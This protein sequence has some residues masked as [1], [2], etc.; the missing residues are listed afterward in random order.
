MRRILLLLS[1]LLAVVATA[2]QVVI[3]QFEVVQLSQDMVT[4][5]N[6]EGLEASFPKDGSFFSFSY[7]SNEMELNIGLPLVQMSFEVGEKTTKNRSS[8]RPWLSTIMNK[9]AAITISSEELSL[10][11]GVRTGKS[12]RFE[13]TPVRLLDKTVLTKV[14]ISDPYSPTR[15]EN[16]LEINTDE[17][18]L[19]GF[20]TIK[21]DE[22]FQHVALYVKASVASTLPQE[23]VYSSGSLDEMAKVFFEEVESEPSE[24]CGVLI[25]DGDFQGR[26]NLVLWTDA[27]IVLNASVSI[28]SMNF[29]AGL[30][31]LVGSEGLRAGAR[32][33]YG[34]E[35]CLALG[36]SDVSQ[37]TNLLSL[38]ASLYPIKISLQ[39][40]SFKSPEWSFGAVLSFD[41]ITIKLGIFS[42]SAMAFSGDVRFNFTKNFFVLLGMAYDFSTNKPSFR[43]GFGVNF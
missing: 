25:Y 34:Q 22:G 24:V 32:I 9:R 27:G 21:K 4:K 6:L 36:F 29:V 35:V 28:P 7:L 1:L 11:T 31:K 12:L 17:F 40:A 15:F 18:S 13:L 14:S 43:V 37:L 5:F 19:I 16:E 8:T 26:V 41:E 10:L 38:F 39:D 30:E 20:V 2:T 42:E 3:Y 23:S 33:S